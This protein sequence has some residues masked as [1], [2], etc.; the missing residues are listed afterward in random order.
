MNQDKSSQIATGPLPKSVKVRTTCNACQQAKIRCSHEKPSCLR[1]QKHNYSCIYSISRRLGRPAKKKDTTTNDNSLHSNQKHGRGPLDKRFRGYPRRKR[2]IE[3]PMQEPRASLSSY[4]CVDEGT[5]L[6]NTA[7]DNLDSL[8]PDDA[9]LHQDC[10]MDPNS[11]SSLSDGNDLSSDNWLQEFMSNPVTDFEQERELLDSLGFSTTKAESVNDISPSH[12]SHFTSPSRSFLTTECHDQAPECYYLAPSNFPSHGHSPVNGTHGV[13]NSRTSDSEVLKKDTLAW[14]QP[15][16]SSTDGIPPTVTKPMTMA[17]PSS[18]FNP[19]RAAKRDT[20]YN[21]VPGNFKAN[22]NMSGRQYQCQCHEPTIRELIQVN[23]FASRAG[24]AATIDS[25]LNCQRVLQQ[26][27]HTILQCNICSRTWINLL[28]MV[29]ISID[30]LVTALEAII[31]LDS[32][33]AERL[34]GEYSEPLSP[35]TKPD[36][37]ANANLRRY[38]ANDLYLNTQVDACPLVVGGFYVPFEEKFLFITQVLYLRLSELQMTVRRIRLC[39]QEFLAV[40]AARGRLVMIME[41]DQSGCSCSI[42]LLQIMNECRNLQPVV[43][44]A[45]ILD[46]VHRVVLQGKAMVKCKGCRNDPHSSFAMLPALAEQ[47]LTLLEAGC[48]A[49]NITSTNTLLDPTVLTFEQ[50]LSQ[51]IC[52]RSPSQLGQMELDEK[53][54][55]LLPA[56]PPGH[57]VLHP[58][59][60]VVDTALR[61]FTVFLEQIKLE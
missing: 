3:E 45:T 18:S 31:S 42:R 34:F 39:T 20:T 44:L 1:C 24:P 35:S 23:N 43:E 38:R 57:A 25:I 48:L 41:T 49:Y 37:V 19:V 13:E 4:K 28:M 54:A 26:L 12:S 9:S 22:A 61:R 2:I 6:D 53:E 32:G 60:S 17:E 36:N 40:P 16:T 51:Y 29:I 7:S 11:M 30:S 46:L 58:C 52:L 10:F 33:L 55:T 14:L 56:F 47:C 59:E 27:S 50:P 8:V 15:V 21:Y 5:V